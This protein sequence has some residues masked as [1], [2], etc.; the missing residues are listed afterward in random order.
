MET[1]RTQ[2]EL[3]IAVDDTDNPEQG[4]TGRVA[5]SIAERLSARF[6]V[7][8]V[9]RHQLAILPEI[10]YTRRNSAN[11]VHLSRRAENVAEL[12]D[13]VAEWLREMALPGA[14]PGLC[15]AAP[16]IVL[17]VEL[18]REAQRRVVG[19]DEVRSAAAAAGAI[20]RH[21]C[22][23]DGGI[24]GAFAAACLASGG[25]DGRF[26]QVGGL[27]SL[28]GRLSVKDVLDAG[29]NEVRT[30]EDIP[31]TEGAI[32]AE[33]LRPALRGGKCVL[34]C[35]RRGDGVWVPII[36]GPGDRE[37]EDSLRATE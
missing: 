17:G 32:L 15:L 8:G 7:W 22:G 12:A 18:G 24:V 11:V 34:Y 27:R 2:A 9:T 10:N 31:L 4:G 37:K 29:G 30:V 14:E 19:K 33:R 23:G 25:D 1:Y 3:V 6:P 21:P 16:E 26:V 28:S 35:S 20:L 36:G 5:R 13:E